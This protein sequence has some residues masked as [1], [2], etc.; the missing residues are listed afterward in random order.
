MTDRPPPGDD[1]AAEEV[2]QTEIAAAEAS[3][4]ATSQAEVSEAAVASAEEGGS[5]GGDRKQSFFSNLTGVGG[6]WISL[7]IVP[8]L[9]VVTALLIGGLIIAF[10]D[11]NTLRQWGDS[12]GEAITDTFSTIVEAYRSLFTGAFGSPKAWSETLTRAAPLILAGL[13][14]AIGFQAGLFNIGANGQI[15]MGG[16]FALVVGF[17]FSVPGIIHIPMVIIAGLVGGAIW[18]GIPGYLRART[19]AHEVITT[20]MFNFIALKLV[21]YWLTIDF[22]QLEGRDDPVSKSVEATARYP[23]L[24]GWLDSSLRLHLGI[25]IAVAAAI[26]IWWLL[27]RSTLG[28][29]FRAVGANP[30]AAKYAGMNVAFLTIAV[31]AIAGS[32]AGLAGVDQ[33]T[34]TLGRATPGFAGVIGFDAIA[35]ALLARSNPIGVIFAGILFGGL[36]AGGQAMQAST[37]VGIDIV[38]VIQALII[39]FIAAPGLVRSLWRLPAPTKEEGIQVTKGW[40]T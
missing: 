9:A 7:Y 24:L 4:T 37:T 8:L 28:F 6:D 31:M 11:L 12:P 36:A 39:V 20:I 22:F 15:L 27:Y 30:H 29:Q 35:L 2:E 18:G 25:V 16:M 21:D 26:F 34:G 38:T 23:K 5:G 17:S 32:M 14:V 3:T 1:A 19:G 10:S 40:A 33:V 13:A